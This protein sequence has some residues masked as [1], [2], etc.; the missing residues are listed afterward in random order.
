[1]SSG[2][3]REFG[4]TNVSLGAKTWVHEKLFSVDQRTYNKTWATM[5]LMSNTE[6]TSKLF[7]S[8]AFLRETHHH[9]KRHLSQR[10]HSQEMYLQAWHWGG[11]HSFTWPVPMFHAD[12]PEQVD[13]LQQP[14]SSAELG[15]LP[16]AAVHLDSGNKISIWSYSWMSISP[17]KLL[18]S[19]FCPAHW[20]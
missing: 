4:S 19:C 18:F 14:L 10:H 7:R 16:Q 15:R 13:L 11:R 12:V 3:K 6:S 8:S 20:S 1:M 2:Y 5:A 9:N 17:H